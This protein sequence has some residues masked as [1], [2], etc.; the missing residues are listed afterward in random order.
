MTA[1]LGHLAER[2][3]GRRRVAVLGDMAELGADAPAYHR[4]VGAVA[5]REGV[6]VLVAVGEL[7]RDYLEGATGVGIRRWAPDADGGLAALREI[8]E[9]GDC[10]LVKGSRSMGLEAVADALAVIA[11]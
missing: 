7:A 11:A 10:V 4:E 2:A 9:P 1:A 6:A 5:A 3:A 8:L